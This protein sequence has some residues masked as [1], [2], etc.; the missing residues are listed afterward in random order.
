MAKS[1]E[2]PVIICTEYRGVFFG[3]SDDTSGDVIH[4]RR[5]RMAI[6]WGT[7]KG[8]MELAEIGPN[9]KSRIS[10]RA[11]LEVRKITAVI[12]VSPQAVDKWE[13]A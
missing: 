10:S 11:D 3:Y 8:V 13:S 6:Y 7:T 4:L 12:E 1:K 9:S 2:R 5:A